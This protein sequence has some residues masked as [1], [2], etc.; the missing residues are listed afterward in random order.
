MEAVKHKVEGVTH[1]LKS[2]SSGGLMN[3]M[4]N[5]LS[6]GESRQVKLNTHSNQTT[7]Q[8]A[9]LVDAEFHPMLRKVNSKHQL[10]LLHQEEGLEGSPSPKNVTFLRSV[11]EICF[12]ACSGPASLEDAQKHQSMLEI[13]GISPDHAPSPDG[14]TKD[15][16]LDAVGHAR[17]SRECSRGRIGSITLVPIS[18]CAGSS[19]LSVV[20]GRDSPT[21]LSSRPTFESALP[22]PESMVSPHSMVEP[23]SVMDDEHAMDGPPAGAAMSITDTASTSEYEALDSGGSRVD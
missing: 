10:H 11:E 1:F 19:P 13:L 2:S 15:E 9:E 22:K 4:V 20:D 6:G 8:R 3:K 14:G 7:L 12:E 16:V 5:A 18:P 23:R 17:H 21:R